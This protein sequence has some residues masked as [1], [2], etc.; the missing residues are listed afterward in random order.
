MYK[1]I[2]DFILRYILYYETMYV[3]ILLLLLLSLTITCCNDNLSDPRLSRIE[4]LSSE[5]PKEALDSLSAICYDLLSDADK[6]Y[7]D[8]LSVKVADKAYITHSTDSIILK[9]INFESKNKSN[10][11][12]P[13]AL[14]Y[15]GR[16]YCDLG[17]YSTALYY[18]QKANDEVSPESTDLRCR[19][20]SQTGRLLTS[21]RLYEQAIPY[22]TSTLEI[23]TSLKDST[24]MTNEL[25]L[26]GGTYLR[27]SNYEQALDCFSQAYKISAQ[28]QRLR[29]KSEMYLAA[30][31]YQMGQI[32]SALLLIRDTPSK[33]SPIVRRSALGYAS[34][35][36]L[37]AGILDTAYM[38]A[39]ELIS[40]NKE[41]ITIGYQVLLSQE[42]RNYI[43]PDSLYQYIYDYRHILETYYDE[44][45]NQLAINQH[46]LFNYQTHERHR[47][48]AEKYNHILRDCIIGF[49]FV[50]LLLSVFVL[51]LRNK[52]K[53][54]IIQLHKALEN[55]D[56]LEHS[57]AQTQEKTP[58]SD[59]PIGIAIS[60]RESDNQTIQDLR[61]RLRHKL[62]QIYNEHLENNKSI[63]ISPSIIESKAYENLQ[64]LVSK[65][66]ELKENSD[67]WKDLEETVIK[68]SPNFKKNLQ[69]LV[70]GK[71]TSYDNHTAI[72]IKCGISLSNMTYLLNRSKGAIVSRRE[73]LC[74]RVFDEKLGTKV[75]DGIIRLL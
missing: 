42:L 1:V 63:S 48:K 18:F 55:I 32:D 30:T 20:L 75:I 72:L 74:F 58:P 57:L 60:N 35:I 71:L 49:V 39:K 11:R 37:K 13:E 64:V 29:A 70:G 2:G 41:H 68:C 7:C 65:K 28:N 4:I 17:D 8:F 38:Y 45:S 47:L 25:L 54:N 73:S 26:L 14:Y 6:H 61:N 22:I 24:G 19:I 69:L 59:N 50:I 10:S 27:N 21:L 16:V 34:N 5:S 9:V 23:E 36:Y 51:T 44:N 67:L 31:K 66:I 40:D 43:H 15:G 46:A 3:R 62:Y 56:Q 53:N 12:Y 52:N 33:V